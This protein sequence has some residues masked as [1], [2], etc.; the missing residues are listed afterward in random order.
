MWWVK[1]SFRSTHENWLKLP[2]V[3]L[4][5]IENGDTRYNRVF[6]AIKLMNSHYKNEGIVVKKF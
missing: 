3:K 2:I 5:Y 6:T 1:I 4:K